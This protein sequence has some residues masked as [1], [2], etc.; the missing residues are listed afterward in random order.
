M[1]NPLCVCVCFFL[2]FLSADL[3]LAPSTTVCEIK[4]FAFSASGFSL[5]REFSRCFLLSLHH[6]ISWISNLLLH[7]CVYV[8]YVFGCAPL[9]HWFEFVRWESDLIPVCMGELCFRFDYMHKFLMFFVFRFRNLGFEVLNSA[10]LT[11]LS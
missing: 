2:L 8:F 5:L 10:M 11:C 6:C 3:K 7:A 4:I 9:I 1:S